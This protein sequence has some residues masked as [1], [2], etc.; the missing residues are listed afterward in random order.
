MEKDQQKSRRAT[1]DYI[2][3]YLEKDWTKQPSFP[4]FLEK[5]QRDEM[6][7]RCLAAAPPEL[8]F[9]A[10]KRTGLASATFPEY[11]DRHHLRRAT[12]APFKDL[13]PTCPHFKGVYPLS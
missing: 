6:M 8:S 5:Q 12:N 11:R 3:F 7:G 4:G 2:P 9:Q 1:K 13:A 10:W